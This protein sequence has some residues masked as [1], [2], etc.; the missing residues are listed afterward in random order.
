MLPW[1]FFIS[2]SSFWNYKFRNVS[3][4]SSSVVPTELQVSFPSYLAIASNVP[5]AITTL[6][7]SCFGQRFCVR[8]RV[9]WALNLL[10]IAFSLM[11][12]LSWPDSERWQGRFLHFTLLLVVLANV[13]VNVLQGAVFGVSGRFPPLYSG[14]VMSGQSLGGVFPAAV[15]VALTSVSVEPKLLGPSAFASIVAFIVLA[16]L[17]F[18]R[19]C[20]HPY[21]VDRTI[22]PGMNEEDDLNGPICYKTILRSCWPYFLTGYVNYATSL[23]IF[24]AITSLGK[25]LR[26]WH[27]NFCFIFYLSSAVESESRSSWGL[28]YFTPVASVLL[29]N[30]GDFLGR[31]LA[32]WLQW[33]SGATLRGR[34]AVLAFTLVR[35]GKAHVKT[36]TTF[37]V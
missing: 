15:A 6:L 17:A 18:K 1:N 13:G 7:H 22:E 26:K 36:D 9:F 14:A 28:H 24:P 31:C 30:V 10:L 34:L 8:K 12:V 19:V 25:F 33:P 11:A 2:I 16:L 21:F 4:N 20:V 27:R 5:G 23:C 3:S 32:T 29:F 35:I 37:D